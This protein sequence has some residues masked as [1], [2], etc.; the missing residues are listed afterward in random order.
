MSNCLLFVILAVAM[1]LGGEQ[2]GQKDSAEKQSRQPFVARVTRP[3]KWEKGCLKV[4]IDRVNRSMAPLFLPFNGLYIEFAVSESSEDPAK[5]KSERWLTAFGASD[6]LFDDVIRLA[7]GASRHDEY[8]VGPTVP[9]VSPEKETRR[10]VPVRGRLRIEAFYYPAQ[11]DW[12]IS[13][14]QREKMAQTPPAKWKNADKQNLKTFTLGLP[15]PCSKV[16]CA[17]ECSGPPVVFE[18]ESMFVPDVLGR[19]DDWISRGRMLNE[20]LAKTSPQC[21]NQN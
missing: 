19:D 10:E 4:S 21:P 20:E 17:P 1:T 15:I 7:P 2:N 14:A 8:C 16:G 18:G 12:Q 11:Q 13:E 5:D 3:L 9:V 6:I